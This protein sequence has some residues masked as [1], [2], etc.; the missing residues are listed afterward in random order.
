MPVRLYE[1]MYLVRADVIDDELKA[2]MGRVADTITQMG[3]E[4][5]LHE[6]WERRA[7]AYPIEGN[8]RGTYC[9]CYFRT[10][11]REMNQLRRELELEEDVLRHI[12]LV[13][14]PNAKIGRASCRERV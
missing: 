1:A 6:I 2:L 13:P 14:N 10:E 11:S 9:I 4:I 3:G 8:L 5:E 7:L 12:I